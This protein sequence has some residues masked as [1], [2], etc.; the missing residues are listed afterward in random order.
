[1][2]DKEKVKWFDE[3]IKWLDTQYGSPEAVME[4]TEDDSD[5]IYMLFDDF[6]AQYRKIKEQ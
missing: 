2:T 5:P 6:V 3:N 1:M 4:A